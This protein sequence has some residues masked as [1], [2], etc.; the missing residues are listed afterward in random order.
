E[1][2]KNRDYSIDGDISIYQLKVDTP[3]NKQMDIGLLGGLFRYNSHQQGWSL[4]VER[5][6]Y[7]G[8]GGIL[9]ET[10]FSIIAK[11]NPDDVQPDIDVR[12]EKFQLESIKEILVNSSLLTKQ[13]Q[14]LL[15]GLNPS[16]MVDTLQFTRVYNKS[17]KAFGFRAHARLKDVSNQHF[18]KIP[19]LTNFSGSLWLNQNK[20]RLD[21]DS[22]EAGID[23]GGLFRAPI[24][25]Q[26]V[27]GSVQWWRYSHGWQLVSSQL[28]AK[29][30]EASTLNNIS[31]YLP[32]T[33]PMYMDLYS[34]FSAAA[35]YKSNY[36]PVK[37]MK[38]PLIDWLDRSIKSGTV[39]NGGVVYRGRVADFP[40]RNP[41]G[42]FAVKL[43][44]DDLELD[45][46]KNW[47]PISQARLE[48]Y[49][50]SKSVD[51]NISEARLLDSTITSTSIDIADYRN[52]VVDINGKVKGTF[53]DVVG[54]VVNSPIP[55]SKELLDI[56][57]K[58]HA[59]TDVGLHIPLKKGST[60]GYSGSVDIEQ[61]AIGLL[62]GVVDISELDGK[63]AFS[64]DG[65][66][67][68]ELSAKIFGNRSGINVYSQ[69]VGKRVKTYLA[70][71][72]ITESA[73][74]LEKFSIPAYKHVNGP[75]DWQVLVD[76]SD[77]Q[78]HVPVLSITS[79]L[80]GVEMAL[81]APFAKPASQS[82]QL[83]I[84]AFFNGGGKSTIYASYGEDF[85]SA[86]NLNTK[87]SGLLIERAHIKFAPEKA[88][89]PQNKLLYVTG[90]LDGFSPVKW[91]RHIAAYKDF[92]LKKNNKLPVFLSMQKL[93]V[94]IDKD[95]G[96][97]E[98][99][100]NILP[101]N[102]PSISG[103]INQFV[104][105]DMPLGKLDIKIKPYQGSLNIVKMDITSPDMSFISSGRW[106]YEHKQ[107]LSELNVK[108][109][110]KNLGKLFN[111]L[112]LA[113][114]INN[115]KADI[116]GNI[117]WSDTPFDFSLSKLN[118]NL[119]MYIKDGSI[120]DIDP[121]AGRVVGLLS[122]SE[123]PRRLMLDFSDMFKKG[124][125]F[126]EI[127]GKFTLS[128]GDANTK[129]IKVEGSVAE[130]ILQGRTGLADRDYDL[131]VNVIPKVGET[132]PVASGA[133]FGTQI[134]ALVYLFEKIM[135]KELEKATEREYRVTG[136][137]DDPVIKRIEKSGKD[138]NVD[139][140]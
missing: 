109:K 28:L 47:P 65:L 14:E 124:F 31:V 84:Q 57:Y 87:S 135:G 38:K 13:H 130:V 29:N 64:N 36:L 53:K 95:E 41:V 34:R 101:D 16:G 39:T 125:V 12:V 133:L 111:R 90:S 19:G 118:G 140:E 49:F 127:K 70:T 92:T 108:M 46:Q 48:A 113:A 122:L 61:G 44:A 20:G 81:P 136:N 129:A 89:L 119:N 10:D 96:K 66:M 103:K 74:L 102:F 32:N 2:H 112:G 54:F 25:L 137:W 94:V 107:H 99:R 76:F 105:D 27:R 115:G 8:I 139:G 123:L 5:F 51:I 33:G 116:N 121:G 1:W 131:K 78:Q 114:I 72:G 22:S 55:A 88:A 18:K 69:V 30:A 100:V 45:Y 59:T 43:N 91:G 67:S 120:A 85:T 35:Q 77:E 9:P 4:A 75:M 63:L 23:F 60:V 3:Q 26:Q 83:N 132:L 71:N 106:N 6:Q 68:K 40:F 42:K 11:T 21:I 134:G 73:V 117:H 97:G 138:T 24:S 86:A 17:N 52:P 79:D 15:L 98:Q 56:E 128:N 37:I 62:A 50:D 104:F 110:S 7:T 93:D 80:V 126:D 58:G 82:S